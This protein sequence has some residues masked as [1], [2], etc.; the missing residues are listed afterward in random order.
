[1]FQ[2]T[3]FM[4]AAVLIIALTGCKA[5]TTG[6]SNAPDTGSAEVE[7][8]LTVGTVSAI[9]ATAAGADGKETAM[10]TVIGA[11]VGAVVAGAADRQLD[12]DYA[13]SESERQAAEDQAA[14]LD[15]QNDAIRAR[16]REIDNDIAMIRRDRAAGRDVSAHKQNLKN[17]LERDRATGAKHLEEVRK[18]IR[19]IEA[20]NATLGKESREERVARAEQDRLVRHLERLKAQEEAL[21]GID[22]KLDERIRT[23]ATL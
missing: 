5:L 23:V 15:A 14:R 18:S 22:A 12:E 1:M 19:E 3:I 2:N 16:F 20:D 17:E 7:G 21:L 8:A 11:G 4:G 10:W 6:N 9:A 13:D